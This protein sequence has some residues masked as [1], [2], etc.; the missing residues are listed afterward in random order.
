MDPASS[1]SSALGPPQYL[2][3]I[4]TELLVMRGMDREIGFLYNHELV[5]LHEFGYRQAIEP[6]QQAKGFLQRHN[7]QR[8]VV[9]WLLVPVLS[10]MA[11]SALL[12]FFGFKYGSPVIAASFFA[13]LI[14]AAVAASITAYRRIQRFSNQLQTPRLFDRWFLQLADGPAV[15]AELLRF[16][17]FIWRMLAPRDRP[18]TL[19]AT[20]RFMTM[21]V[22]ST[23][24]YP[25][26][27]TIN[28]WNIGLFALIFASSSSCHLG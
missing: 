5:P 2:L 9:R 11:F 16:S 8:E 7:W 15:M 24:D 26:P 22:D 14:L 28:L 20:V 6:L 1:D 23:A 13:T 27:E 3:D 4:M 25:Q 19:V 21:H 10:V 18:K 12:L 17:P